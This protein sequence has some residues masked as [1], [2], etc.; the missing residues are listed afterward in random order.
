MK[1]KETLSHFKPYFVEDKVVPIRLDANESPYDMPAEMK[2]ELF[3]ELTKIEVNRY[4]D[5]QVK[6]LRQ[7]ISEKNSVSPE[8][9]IFGNGSDEFIYMLYMCLKKG[10]KVA[11]PEPGFSM[12]KIVGNIF[13]MELIPYMLLEPGYVVNKEHLEDILKKGIDLIFLGNP[14][15]PTGSIFPEEYVEMVLSYSNTILVSDEAYF[16]YSKNTLVD[17]VHK[18]RN[19]L[20]MRSFSKVGFAG[21]RLGYM[22]GNKDIISK[23][24]MVRSPYNINSFTQ[25]VAEFYFKYESFFE[26]RVDKIIS[27]RERV[28]KLLKENNILV[29]PSKA[30]FLTFRVE[31]KGL[32][33][34]MLSKGIKI[35]DLRHSFNMPNYYRVTIGEDKENEEFI[36][37]LLTFINQ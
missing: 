2:E 11:F 33:E 18:Y 37:H 28:Y 1:F 12:Y 4:P 14:N 9:I 7:I 8:S 26:K 34:Y 13:E 6:T 24:N 22:I 17:L 29:I 35:K 30:N 10:A 23:L 19:L 25:K 27:E 16:N 31:K 32:Y 20:V 3:R 21:I 36:H 5:S 15:N